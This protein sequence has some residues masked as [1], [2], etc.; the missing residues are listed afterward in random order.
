MNVTIDHD[1]TVERRVP[2]SDLAGGN[3]AEAFSKTQTASWQMS[4]ASS[5]CSFVL[6]WWPLFRRQK[7]DALPNVAFERSGNVWSLG[8]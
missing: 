4:D 2:E 3:Y 8:V 1:C 6:P 7:T 5:L